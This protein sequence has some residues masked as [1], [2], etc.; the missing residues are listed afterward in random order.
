MNII[1]LLSSKTKINTKLDCSVVQNFKMFTD[2]SHSL[3]SINIHFPRSSKDVFLGCIF[4]DWLCII[5]F[6]S[7][8]SNLDSDQNIM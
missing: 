8:N 6:Q 4:F 1:E 5:P 3:E 2:F 7:V